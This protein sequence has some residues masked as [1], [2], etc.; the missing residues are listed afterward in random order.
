MVRFDPGA[1]IRTDRRLI[2]RMALVLAI[3]AIASGCNDKH[4][5]PVPA[6]PAAPPAP[7]SPPAPVLPQ[8]SPQERLL[9]A[10]TLLNQ[11]KAGEA[12]AYLLIVLADRPADRLALDLM[13]QIDTDPQILLGTRSYPYVLR[14]GETLSSIAGRLLGDRNRF[15]ALARYN[16]IAVP[17]EAETGRTIRIPGAAPAAP[18]P[19]PAPAPVEDVRPRPAAVVP[20][21]PARNPAAAGRLRQQGLAAMASGA[22]NRAVELLQRALGLDP[23]NAT[24][25]GDLARARRVQATVQGR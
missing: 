19:R 6:A 14:R 13:R 17:A 15:W 12:R 11:G 10:L 21:L 9:N 5:K 22:I 1:T 24:I 18:Q 8:Q 7:P 2:A 23:A 4:P 25:L 3:V 20:A 16:G